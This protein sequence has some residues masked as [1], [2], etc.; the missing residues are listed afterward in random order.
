MT[1]QHQLTGRFAVVTGAA[2]GI[3]A[4]IARSLQ[5]AGAS[6][7][8]LD[9][10]AGPD[11]IACD[12]AD[13]GQIAA[14]AAEVVTRFGRVDILVNNAGVNEKRGLDEIDLAHLDRLIG[15]NLRAPIL[16]TAALARHM[17]PGGRIINIASELAYTGRACGSVYAATKGAML[18]LTRSWARELAPG[19]LV[20]AV[21]PGPVDT[22]MLGFATLPPERRAAETDNPLG[23][24]GEVSEIAATVLFLCGPGGNLYTGQCLGP[25]GG[26]VM[27]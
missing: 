4:E 6:V 12:L 15:I 26:I 1:L 11:C 10:E 16:L 19:I 5:E 13:P 7:L 27:T 17:A 23:R 22:G 8:G 2:Q 3:G 14:A 9:R 18:S 20:N 24:I 21:A 25:N